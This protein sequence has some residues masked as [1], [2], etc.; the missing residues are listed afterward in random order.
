MFLE[1]KRDFFP[2][3]LT[4]CASGLSH[5]EDENVSFNWFLVHTIKEMSKA[6]KVCVGSCFCECYCPFLEKNTILGENWE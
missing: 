1:I 6:A 5:I 3:F 4:S 2:L